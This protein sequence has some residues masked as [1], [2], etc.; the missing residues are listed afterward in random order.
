MARFARAAVDTAVDSGELAYQL[1]YSYLLP[2]FE[3][4]DR[5]TGDKLYSA[6]SALV[7]TPLRARLRSTLNDIL[8]LTLAAPGTT[9]AEDNDLPIE[10]DLPSPW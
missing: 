8:G 7:G 1:F 9:P 6:V 2:Q 5:K 3:G 10:P 4:I